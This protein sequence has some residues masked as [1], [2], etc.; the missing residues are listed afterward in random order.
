MEGGV[1]RKRISEIY[2][3]DE[4]DFESE[5]AYNDYL[6]MP[7]GAIFALASGEKVEEIEQQIA[8]YKQENQQSIQRYKR[9]RQNASAASFA[10][11]VD[12]IMETP[13]VDV[14]QKSVRSQQPAPVEA[15]HEL[16]EEGCLKTKR[17]PQTSSEAHVMARAAGWSRNDYCSF[18]KKHAWRIFAAIDSAQSRDCSMDGGGFMNAEDRTV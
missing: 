1:G 8:Q 17:R 2:T 14:S 4:S 16:T 6:E 13:Q 15:G 12:K 11:S 18:V 3:K 9:R 7:E 10:F 5:K